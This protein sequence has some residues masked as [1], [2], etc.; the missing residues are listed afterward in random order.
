MKLARSIAARSAAT[1]AIGKRAFYAQRDLDLADAYE[2]ASEAMVANLLHP[3]SDE[4]ISAFLERREPR[5]RE[6]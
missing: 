6:S 1:I 2:L 4:G 3:D 5:W